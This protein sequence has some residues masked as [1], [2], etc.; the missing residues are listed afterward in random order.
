MS[1]FESMRVSMSGL[2]AQRLRMDVIASNVANVDTTRTPG[3]GPYQRRQVIFTAVP[4]TDAQLASRRFQPVLSRRTPSAGQGVAVT[5]IAAQ[6]DAV[7][8]V[9]E[10][11]HPDA[12]ENGFVLRPD[13]DVI[14]EM[15]DLLAASRAYE[16][17]ITV[18]NALKSMANRALAI[19]RA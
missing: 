10:P 3:G 5:A 4:N 17:N 6:P 15:T 13:I 12:D 18:L 19:G 11:D 16:A 7:R 9:Y 14:T 8:E 2:S 1:I